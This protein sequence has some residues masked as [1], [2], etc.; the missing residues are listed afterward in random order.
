MPTKKST[1]KRELPTSEHYSS[2]SSSFGHSGAQKYEKTKL[3]PHYH[4][5]VSY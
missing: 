4:V 2:S 3:E 5:V 1:K